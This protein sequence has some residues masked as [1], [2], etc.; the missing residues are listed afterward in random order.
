M[1][2]VQ[3]HVLPRMALAGSVPA[4]A[5]APALLFVACLMARG[6]SDAT[7]ALNPRCSEALA[8]RRSTSARRPM[9]PE[10]VRNKP[11]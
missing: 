10:E 1:T 5:T 11:K 4:Y 9:A 7:S 6:C 3:A 2:P 8:P